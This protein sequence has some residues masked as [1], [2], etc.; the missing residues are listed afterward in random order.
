MSSIIRNCIS[1][2]LLIIW[3]LLCMFIH[4]LVL[5][6][7]RV[8]IYHFFLVNVN[9]F[10]IWYLLTDLHIHL[11]MS[12][13][14]EGFWHWCAEDDIIQELCN[15]MIN[16]MINLVRCWLLIIWSLKAGFNQSVEFHL[17]FR[18]F[19]IEKTLLY[20]PDTIFKIHKPPASNSIKSFTI[21]IWSNMH[22]NAKIIHL[23]ASGSS[24][25]LTNWRWALSWSLFRE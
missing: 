21:F 5:S 15:C 10:A 19:S 2:I 14:L 6:M 16:F 24:H 8:F 25:L 13:R 18:L 4:S 23:N 11:E 7:K 9:G 22:F 17:L 1:V 12:C 20:I 3:I